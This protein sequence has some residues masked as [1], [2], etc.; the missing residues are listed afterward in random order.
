[1]IISDE[2]ERYILKRNKFSRNLKMNFKNFVYYIFGNIGK[3]SILEL[4]EFSSIKNGSGEY[5]L[6]NKICLSKNHFSVL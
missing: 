6:L 3:T 5:L 1:M 2:K 4:G